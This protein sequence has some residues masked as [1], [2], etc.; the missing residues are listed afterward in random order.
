MVDIHQEGCSLRTA[1]R[2]DIWHTWI[3]ALM[4]HQETEQPVLGRW[5]R[6]TACLGQCAHKHLV[7]WAA[8]TWEGH[9]TQ[10]LLWTVPWRECWSLSSVDLESTHHCELGQTQCGPYTE[11]TPQTC[12]WYLFPVFLPPHNTTEQVNLSKWLPSPP[13]VRV[14]VRHQ[15]DLQTEEAKINKEERT[16]LEVTDGAVL[17]PL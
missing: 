11:G 14:E 17:R 9:K 12:Q 16:A 2:R 7:A 13:C 10:G 6:R 8:W 4:A 15:T 3:G 1:P 5:L